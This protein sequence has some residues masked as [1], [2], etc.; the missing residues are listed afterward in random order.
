MHRGISSF[1]AFIRPVFA[2]NFVKLLLL[3]Q[4]RL[5]MSPRNDLDKTECIVLSCTDCQE[6]P[7]YRQAGGGT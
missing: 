4:C 2:E 5:K 7:M 6:Q 1:A 3:Q